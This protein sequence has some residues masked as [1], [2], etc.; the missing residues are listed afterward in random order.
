M[1][2]LVGHCS[3]AHRLQKQQ[4]R[5]HRRRRQQ[6]QQTRQQQLANRRTPLRWWP[7]AA[8]PCGRPR[9][10]MTSGNGGTTCTMCTCPHSLRSLRPCHNSNANGWWTWSKMPLTA[11]F[12]P[13]ATESRSGQQ[14][15]V[16]AAPLVEG[17]AFALG[18]VVVGDVYNV[19]AEFVDTH[20]IHQVRCLLYHAS[21]C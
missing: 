21:P 13:A 8:C 16:A 18:S 9:N 17:S 4:R 15:D 11:A 14:G 20:T 5:K 12:S 1:T 19:A 10:W 6:Q 2:E 3:S 7:A